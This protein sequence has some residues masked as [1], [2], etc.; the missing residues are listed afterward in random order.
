MEAFLVI[1]VVTVAGLTMRVSIDKFFSKSDF[2]KFEKIKSY[3][4]VA[5]Y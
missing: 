1:P 5:Q 2:V 4:L 3:L